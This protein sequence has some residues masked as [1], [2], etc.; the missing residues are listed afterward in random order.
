MPSKT[1]VA[2]IG[3]VDHGKSTL[4]GQL[5]AT[6]ATDSNIVKAFKDHDPVGDTEP[7]HLLDQLVEERENAMTID[8]TQIQACIEDRSFTLIDAPGHLELLKNM[9]AGTCRADAAVLVIDG[10]RGIEDQTERHLAVAALLGC[11]HLIVVVNKMDLVNYDQSHFEE[12]ATDIYKLEEA[13]GMNQAV[14]IPVAARRNINVTA[15]NASLLP[16]YQGPTL[17]K[18]LSAL[19]EVSHP[20]VSNL[21]L[22]IQDIYHSSEETLHVGQIA[23]G[24]LEVGS[25]LWCGADQEGRYLVEQIS[26]YPHDLAKAKAGQ[27]VALKLRPL[28]GARALVRGDILHDGM[29]PLSQAD[30]VEGPFVWLG[31]QPLKIA[32]RLTVRCQTQMVTGKVAAIGTN[33]ASHRSA[34]STAGNVAMEYG[35]TGP[36]RISL[37]QP[38][39][40]ETATDSQVPSPSSTRV[41]LEQDGKLVA[42]G[43]VVPCV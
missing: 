23:S 5:A 4:L 33:Y 28:P 43:L 34:R 19:P 17:S 9:V 39:V 15:S 12:L 36:I 13:N 25:T 2:F 41:V 22:P 18:A 30:A 31:K 26:I 24:I 1:C 3:H 6:T 29:V 37:D 21:R 32:D 20:E 8:T 11:Q 42:G 38:L 40:T 27:S 35:A 10:N 7:A 14:I 16:W